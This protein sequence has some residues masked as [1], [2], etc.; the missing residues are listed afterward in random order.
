MVFVVSR[1]EKSRALTQLT[2]KPQPLSRRR[3]IIKVELLYLPSYLFTITIVSSNRGTSSE[4][5]CIDGIQGQF[6]FFKD[7]DFV[8]EPPDKSRIYNFVISQNDAEKI[9]LE[10]YKRQLLKHS[11]KKKV[12]VMVK[13]IQFESKIHYPYWIG[14]FH[15]KGALDFE[16]IDGLSA[17][18][19]GVKMKPIF[20]N[21]LLQKK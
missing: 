11:L 12:T 8:K 14:Y 9:A 10:D 7:A 4:Q 21:L 15:R 18:R 17:E 3:N 6:A 16:V 13:S 1:V 5:V 2:K 20:V 19:Q